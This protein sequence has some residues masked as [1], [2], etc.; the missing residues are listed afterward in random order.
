MKKGNEKLIE[1]AMVPN[2]KIQFNTKWF[3]KHSMGTNMNVADIM[4]R[5]LAIENYYGKN[6]FGFELYNEMQKIRVNNNSEI[7][8][9]RA[10]NQ[11]QF[12]KLID[13]FER[14]GYNDK[15]PVVVNEDFK[16]FDGT[17]RLA[18]SLYF[19]IENIPVT[20]K[21]EVIERHPDYSLNWFKKV[22]LEEY[23]PIIKEKYNKLLKE[24]N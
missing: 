1:L 14:N 9:Y 12:I 21:S 20:F 3:L 11:E 10:N 2:V 17:H 5:I 7:P 23:I 18:C 16:L 8:P 22:G 15:Y 6:N 19:D 24:G 4:I 13:S